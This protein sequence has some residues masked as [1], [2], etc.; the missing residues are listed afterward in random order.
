MRKIILFILL[1]AIA[2][3]PVLRGCKQVKRTFRPASPHESYRRALLD[4][5]LADK[6]M[7]Q[8]WIQA[9]D[10]ALSRA[11]AA[12]IPQK[13]MLT[14]FKDEPVAYSWKIEMQ[15]G[16]ALNARIVQSDTS[17]Q[18]F[19]DLFGTEGR[20]RERIASAEDSLLHYVSERDHTVILRLQPE[21][22]VSGSLTLSITDRPSMDFPVA[23]ASA[24]HIKS[25][26]GAP[27]DG[28]APGD[29]GSSP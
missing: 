8:Q 26:W 29:H 22:L 19:M 1:A 23:G 4:S 20:D 10:S 15:E 13:T 5:K 11:R 3:A 16:R 6:P 21:L 17:H 14:Y 25:F 2:A 28:G 12:D 27:R 24:S 18:I 7:V 9:A